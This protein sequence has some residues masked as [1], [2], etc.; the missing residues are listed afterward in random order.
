MNGENVRRIYCLSGLGAD[1][2]IF[3][4]LVIPGVTF[5]HLE[6]VQPLQKSESIDQYARRL[7]DAIE[8]EQPVL[9]GV[10]F[11]GMM[12]I[13][14][15]KLRPVRAV[16]LVSSIKSVNELPR[17]MKILGRCRAEFLIPKV[18]LKSIGPLKALRPI[19]NY[20]LGASTD[21]EIAIANEFRD[22]VDPEYL[23]WSLRQIFN[24]KND[25]Q[26]EQV[27]HIHGDNDKLF[28]LKNLKPTHVIHEGGHFMVMSQCSE[29]SRIVCEICE[30]IRHEP[31]KR[32][33][34][35]V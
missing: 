12:A 8:D 28:P 13:E 23:K 18:P 24:W 3:D 1:K 14:I 31:A 32:I 35:T 26:P 30:Q 10:S 34:P 6:W 16:I 15:A 19:Q 2:R 33:I 7:T 29:V 11:G 20:F 4:Q 5:I 17:W 25:W 22:N 9:M 27:F 21:L